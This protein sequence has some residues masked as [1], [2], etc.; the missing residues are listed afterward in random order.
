[1][2]LA[3]QTVTGLQNIRLYRIAYPE[4]LSYL[5]R[6]AAKIAAEG[7]TFD[8][9]VKMLEAI[10]KWGGLTPNQKAAV[11][12]MMARDAG[13]ALAPVVLVQ[14]PVEL[15]AS[16]IQAAFDRSISAAQAAGEGI[17]WLRLR[18]DTF[19]FTPAAASSRNPGAIYVKEDG[20]YLGKIANGRFHKVREC[21]EDQ[22]RRIAEVARDPS[23]AA[24]AY[25]LRTGSCSICGRELTNAESRARGIGPICAGRMGL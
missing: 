24:R 19:V 1:M 3:L 23:E 4:M 18:A 22:A 10:A 15:D 8:F 21:S 7:G 16:K 2:T 12:K 9:P 11:E 5:E 17:K 14:A 13:R 20:T 25:G 6:K